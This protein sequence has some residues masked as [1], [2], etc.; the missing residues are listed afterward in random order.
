MSSERVLN[1][2]IKTRL[3]ETHLGVDKSEAQRAED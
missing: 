1:V 3:A 2:W